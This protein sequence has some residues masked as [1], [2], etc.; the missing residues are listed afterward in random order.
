MAAR[1]AFR[2]KAVAPLSLLSFPLSNG[3]F[4]ITTTTT[5][6]PTTTM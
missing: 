4:L 3:S 2:P 5:T 1:Q 6:T